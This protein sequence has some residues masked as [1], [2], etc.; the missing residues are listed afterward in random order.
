MSSDYDNR[1]YS[2]IT[3]LKRYNDRRS[4]H[5]DLTM[6]NQSSRSDSEPQEVVR[7]KDQQSQ[8]LE[9]NKELRSNYCCFS[10]CCLP[11]LYLPPQLS[12][13]H[14]HR[15]ATH[16]FGIGQVQ[17]RDHITVNPAILPSSSREQVAPLSWRLFWEYL[18]RIERDSQR[19]VAS[20]TVRRLDL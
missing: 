7:I 14:L 15:K 13:L 19:Q 11:L 8:W 4:R 20:L 10:F 1:N 16:L 5:Q 9:L 18:L 6:L 3:Y 2:T 12:P 17:E